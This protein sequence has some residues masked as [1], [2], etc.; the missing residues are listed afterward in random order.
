[1]NNSKLIV[2]AVPLTLEEPAVNKTYL[3]ERETE[4]ASILDALKKVQATK[5]W[6]TLKTKLFDGI[7]DS[8]TRDMHN[9]AKKEN[10]DTLKLNRLAGQ[11][12]W[13]EKYSDLAKLE[14]V[15]RTELVSIKQKL[16]GS[17]E[18]TG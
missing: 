13:A 14:N 8:L 15:F 9:E 18:K 1:M 6:S 2:D 12:K 10:P 3:R 5:E 16:Y 7:V 4:I 11:L 17:T